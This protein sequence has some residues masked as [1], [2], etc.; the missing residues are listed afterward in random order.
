MN[1]NL[2]HT[3]Y[4]CTP[5]SSVKT[6]HNTSS[7]HKRKVEHNKTA[8]VASHGLVGQADEISHVTLFSL[9]AVNANDIIALAFSVLSHELISEV[10]ID[11]ILQALFQLNSVFGKMYIVCCLKPDSS[12]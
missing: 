5:Y 1:L 8:F 12:L 9:L 2:Q 7:F 6:R 4:H 3:V 10:Y 11:L